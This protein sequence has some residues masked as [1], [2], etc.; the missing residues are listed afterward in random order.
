M[1]VTVSAAL[2]GFA[3]GLSLILVI[4][5]QNAFVL[6]Q[7]LARRHVFPVCLTCALSDATLIV[8]G[9]AGFGWVV[10]AVPWLDDV[11]RWGGAAFLLAYG[12]FSFR[13]AWLGGGRLDAADRAGQALVPTLL[14]VLALTW[15]NPHVWLDTVVLLGGIAAQWEG[16]RWAFGFGAALA[17][18]VFFF[19]LGYGARALAPLFRRPSAWRVLDIGIGVIMWAIAAKLI[20]G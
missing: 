9:V 8:F 1:P 13:S 2:T 18:F 15:L 16:S 7:G 17:S 5:A 4:G 20:L 14:T 19:S 3:L 11:L 10:T 6:R 12:A